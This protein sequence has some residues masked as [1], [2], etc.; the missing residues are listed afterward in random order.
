MELFD[1][2]CD[3]LSR[4]LAVGEGLWENTGHLDLR[5]TAGFFPYAQIFAI[6]ADE[7][8]VGEAGLRRS[9]RAQADFFRREM[10]KHRDKIVLCRSGEEITAAHRSGRA[11]AL[12]SV[13]GGELLDCDP[14][15]L[16]EAWRIGVRA[17]NLTWNH[18]N[19]LSGSHCDRPEQGLTRRGS[20][21]VRRMEELGMLVDVSHLSDPGFWDVVEQTAGPILASHSNA[22]AVFF[23]TRNLTDRQITAIIDRKGVIGLNLFPDFFGVGADLDTV[24]AHLE[25]MLALGGAE[26]VALGGDWDGV[27]RLPRGV[28]DIR[29]AEELRERLLQRNYAESLVRDLFYSNM[30][31]IV[32]EKCST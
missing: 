23:H 2:H 15:K 24:I 17:V 12:L 3:T 11:A 32:S 10:E 31:R 30:M 18:A 22:R 8:E 28:R 21:F 9:F 1:A 13:E 29:D 20:A 16:E 19:A 4:C 6:F 14:A 7:D 5:R 26:T 27:D 25:H